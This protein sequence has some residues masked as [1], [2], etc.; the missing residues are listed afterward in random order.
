MITH[1]L[2]NREYR[3]EIALLRRGSGPVELNLTNIM[4]IIIVND[5]YEPFP[6]MTLTVK[7]PTSTVIPYF[8]ADSDSKIVFTVMS[9][10]RYGK[11]EHTT[12]KSHIF[13]ID[14]VK[15]LNFSGDNNTYEIHA[16][17][18]FISIWSNPISFSTETA[19]IST[20]ET[21]GNILAKANIPFVRPVSESSH[22]QF[23]VTDINTPLSDHIQRLLDFAS[24]DRAGFYYT[25]YDMSANKLRIESTKNLMRNKDFHAYNIITISSGEYG[26]TETYTPKSVHYTNDISATALDS[27]AKGI[28][29]FNFDFTKGKFFEKKMEFIDIKNSSTISSLDSV[30]NKSINID[31]DT[32]YTQ[33]A[34]GHNS[35][36]KMR[37]Y[38]RNANTVSLEMA[39]TLL[40]N[41][42]DLVVLKSSD[43]LQETFGGLWITMRTIESFNFGTSKFDQTIIVSKVGKI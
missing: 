22:K 3:F 5:S 40:R 33:M 20:T 9:D 39:G 18:E 42:G 2:N 1:T 24:F 41:I 25:W 43:S 4:N 14:H 28:K 10:E 6:R 8:M 32:N 30:I 27:M 26:S 36:A 38:I 34:T 23:Y 12:S 11:G 19:N 29:E 7:D 13:N 31:S 21:A 16:V 17:S 37:K 35:Y 15:P